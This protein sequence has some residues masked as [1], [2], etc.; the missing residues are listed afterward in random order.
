MATQNPKYKENQVKKAIERLN[1]FQLKNYTYLI[2]NQND[3]YIKQIAKR[4]KYILFIHHE[5]TPRFI[6]KDPSYDYEGII[7]YMKK[8]IIENFSSE[9]VLFL[10]TII[11]TITDNNK[12]ICK[13]IY[14]IYDEE[15]YHNV[16]SDKAIYNILYTKIP[17]LNKST[18]VETF[19]DKM[20]SYWSPIFSQ[21]VNTSVIEDNFW[22][23]HFGYNIID[24]DL[25]NSVYNFIGDKNVLSIM[26]GNGLLEYLLKLKNIDITITTKFDDQWGI[27]TYSKD[28]TILNMDYIDAIKK[29]PTDI[30][31]VSWIPPNMNVLNIFKYFKGDRLI[32]LGEV[33][34]A[35]ATDKFYNKLFD[36]YDCE[37]VNVKNFYGVNNTL[38]LCTRKGLE[39]KVLT[40]K[41]LQRKLGPNFYV[42]LN[43]D[44]YN[45]IAELSE[46]NYILYG[47]LEGRIEKDTKFDL[48]LLNE[49]LPY[50]DDH[51]IN[52][53]EKIYTFE[54]S[55]P[56][57]LI[58]IY[59]KNNKNEK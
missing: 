58:S 41:S 32:I 45:G 7:Y 33:Y 2:Q 54:I 43:E 8:F 19:I 22:R 3:K 29:F 57:E 48:N 51:I 12:I 44:L 15:E 55:S 42:I 23:K 39:L 40:N 30:L 18:N 56:Q 37:Y 6:I 9:E 11:S 38:L 46:D 4:Q 16:L 52:I 36:Q 1:E 24:H 14:Y 50:D 47:Y 13:F 5:R 26:A 34:G 10:S 28:T 21:Y 20:M 35:S 59:T 25:F 17:I 27:N 49:I 31:M 53:A